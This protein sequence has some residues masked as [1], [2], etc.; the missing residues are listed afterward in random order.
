[1]TAACVCFPTRWRLTSKT[2]RSMGAIHG[3]VPRYASDLGAKADR[4]LDRLRVDHPVWR[5]NWT[6][7]TDWGNR[8][9][10]DRP[11]LT[12]P[13]IDASNVAERLCLRLEYQTLR[14]F[15]GHDTILFTIR[16]LRRPLASVLG[17]GTGAQLAAALN[18]MPDDVAAY[19]AGTVLY[20]REILD[21]LVDSGINIDGSL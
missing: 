3:P 20:R 21:W 14:R 16:I 6:I 5:T 17:D 9:E 10:P 18:S 11:V 13:T 19:K 8:L 7:D 12:D 1:M 15:P 2:G 4:F